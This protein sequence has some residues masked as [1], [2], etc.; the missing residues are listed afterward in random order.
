MESNVAESTSKPSSSKPIDPIYSILKENKIDEAIEYVRTGKL[1]PIDCEDEHGTT[2]LQYAAFRGHYDLCK[3]LIERGANVNAKSHDQGYSALMFAA[4]S[5]HVQ[6]VRLLLDYDADPDYTNTIGRTAAQM[7]T[8]VNSNDSA[9]VINSYVSKKSIEYYTE[10][11]SID[12]KEPKLPKGEC[13]DELHKLVTTSATNYAP[14]RIFKS[15]KQANNNVLM[16]NIDRVIRTLDAFATRAFRDDRNECPN[17]LLSFKMHYYKYQFEFLR[18]QRKKLVEAHA[19]LSA[20][21]I[22]EKLFESCIR[23]LLSEEKIQVKKEGQEAFERTYRVFEER[24][25]RESIRQYPYKEC[26]L[27]RQMVTILARAPVGTEPSALYVIKS[28]LNGQKFSES[29]RFDDKDDDADA[30]KTEKRKLLECS[31]CTARSY[32]AK[33]CTHCHKVAYCDQ[34]CQRLHWPIHK[35]QQQVSAV[36]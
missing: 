27:V 21:E 8:F 19:S 29:F 34:Y 28:C 3:L 20:Q 14:V 32:D 6:V 1:K 35:K 7:A 24:Y 2:P 31:T 10:I 13:A 11:H 4:I 26:A 36:A 9:D 15:I 17:D 23:M 25:I 30:T 5:N 22:D 33:W 12:E 16:A 18:A